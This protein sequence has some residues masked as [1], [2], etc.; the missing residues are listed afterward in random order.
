MSGRR[1][2]K[3][4]RDKFNFPPRV[5]REVQR[6][7]QEGEEGGDSLRQPSFFKSILRSA[8]IA[9]SIYCNF[10]LALNFYSSLKQQND[11]NLCYFDLL[12]SPRF[13]DIIFGE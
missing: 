2:G 6:K 11:Q 9:Y 1:A 7:F 12:K 13:I 10:P 3:E 5:P 4:N 8:Y